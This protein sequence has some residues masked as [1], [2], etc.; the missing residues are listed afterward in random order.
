[1]GSN[2]TG[3]SVPERFQVPNSFYV[4]GQRFECPGAEVGSV[5]VS[6]FI[7]SETVAVLHDVS[8]QVRNPRFFHSVG[9]MENLDF[10][11]EVGGR[12]LRIYY[13]L[14]LGIGRA[15]AVRCP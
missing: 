14:A 15:I 6:F 5:S 1:M 11:T 2:G 4:S 12:L 9:G 8:V 3:V 10:T 7:G 13:T